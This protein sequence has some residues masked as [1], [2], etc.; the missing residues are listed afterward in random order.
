MTNPIRFR[1]GV[2][3]CNL[4]SPTVWRDLSCKLAMFVLSR[5]CECEYVALECVHMYSRGQHESVALEFV[6]TGS[7]LP[8]SW[9]AKFGRFPKNVENDYFKGNVPTKST[10]YNTF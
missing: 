2:R 5:L 10:M 7:K 9:P 3:Q 1:H 4:N 8:I 6:I